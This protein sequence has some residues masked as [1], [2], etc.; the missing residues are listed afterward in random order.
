MLGILLRLQT[1]KEWVF[2]IRTDWKPGRIRN[3]TRDA[4]AEDAIVVAARERLT[5]TLTNAG[6]MPPRRTKIG[7]QL[8]SRFVS[9]LHPILTG[10]GSTVDGL[11]SLREGWSRLVLDVIRTQG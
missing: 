4:E 6:L 3:L 9:K 8:L 5:N 11:S 7:F 10:L 2:I 1:S